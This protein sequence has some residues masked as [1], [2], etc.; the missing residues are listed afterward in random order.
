VARRKTRRDS[1]SRL[2]DRRAGRGTAKAIIG[3]DA[4]GTST[5]LVALLGTKRFEI[6]GGSGNLLTL[7]ESAFQARLRSCAE[8]LKKKSGTAPEEFTA[9]CLGGAGLGRAAE[10]AFAR[11]CLR[12]LWPKAVI[13][14]LDDASLFLHAAFGRGPGMA[15]LAG[16]GSICVGRNPEGRW[17]RTG[18]WG[19]QLGDPG[20]AFA[21]GIAS[22]RH[23]A[24]VQDGTAGKT[25]FAR[26]LARR[27][28]L[29]DAARTARFTARAGPEGV[30]ALAPFVLLRARKGDPT[31]VRIVEEESL[32]L[33]ALAAALAEALGDFG[34]RIALGGGLLKRRFYADS[35][36]KKLRREL[37]DVAFR[38]PRRRPVEGALLLA[39]A[40]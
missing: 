12:A 5:R 35:V 11:R 30:A 39:R 4:G 2:G 8:K 38:V 20:S 9:V 21:L 36:K 34:G 29:S 26:S 22:L 28:R 3:I 14:V 37:P 1:A 23:L 33:A 18:G 31:A 24:A 32:G 16:T 10:K 27:L 40:L 17:K 15:V 6:D 7:G 25:D 19:P 13:K